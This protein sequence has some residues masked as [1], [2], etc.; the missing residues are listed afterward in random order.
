MTSEELA[1]QVEAFIVAAVTR[2]RGTGDDQYS[3]GD[4][5]YFET[6]TMDEQFDELRDELY[7]VANYSVMLAIKIDRLQQEIGAVVRA[8]GE[9][10]NASD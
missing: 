9:A 5:Q 6:R 10:A 4:R 1:E 3:L 7:D 8:A 2:V